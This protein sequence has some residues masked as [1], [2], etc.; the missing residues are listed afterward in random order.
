MNRRSIA[1]LGFAAAMLSPAAAHANG[2][3]LYEL[4]PQAIA[5]GGAMVADGSDPSAVAHNPAAMTRLPGFQ[6]QLNVTTYISQNSF[7]S[8]GTDRKEN[9]ETG[10][11]P[12]P[13]A[14]AT[15]QPTRKLTLGIGSYCIYGLALTW[16]DK[17]TGY[18]A[19]KKASLRSYQVQP[20]FAVGPFAGLSFGGGLDVV[21]G[22]VDLQKGLPL[23]SNTFGRTTIGGTTVGIGANFGLFYEPTDW[24]RVGAGY[25]TPL[26]MKL[27]PGGASFESNA[28]FDQQ[29]KKQDVRTA[30]NLP[31]I[32]IVG[33]RFKPTKNFQ[34]EVDGW[35]A[36]WNSYKELNFQFDD[37]SLNQVEKKN[38]HN[39]W[40]LRMGGQYDLDKLALRAGFV[41]VQ[42]PI[43][44]STLDPSLPDST[45]LIPSVGA[46]YQFTKAFRADLGYHF[47]YLLPRS[48]DASVN[49]L[50]G[51]YRGSVNSIVVGATIQ[52]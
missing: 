36:Q 32:F 50:P 10:V 49:R 42:S 22:A 44:D 16:P 40:D 45:R 47:V 30:L 52:L 14:F 9:A 4:N 15:W 46:G 28:T 29:L 41:Y 24:L 11:F 17:W 25:R 5:Q 19:V 13:T 51:E 38:W 39:A 48:V 12:M 34:F 18:Q 37:P 7:K 27:D 3:V 8:Q 1:V 23:G 20:S 31:G 35:L 33:A 2:F 26:T 21:Y 43:P 6:A